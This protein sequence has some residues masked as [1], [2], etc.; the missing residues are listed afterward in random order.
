METD[1]W[2]RVPHAVPNTIAMS[3]QSKETVA[4]VNAF[5]LK[6]SLDIAQDNININKSG[7]RQD[8]TFEAQLAIVKKIAKF[9]NTNWS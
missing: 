4:S 5:L 9:F 8:I 6:M 2:P 3:P 1:P 7:N